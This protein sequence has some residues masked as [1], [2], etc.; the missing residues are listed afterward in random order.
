[1]EKIKQKLQK[2]KLKSRPQ[3]NV[4]STFNGIMWIFASGGALD[5]NRKKIWQME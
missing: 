3:I 4:R 5:F 2:E 1:M